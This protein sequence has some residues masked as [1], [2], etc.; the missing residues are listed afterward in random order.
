MFKASKFFSAIAES[1]NPPW[2]AVKRNFRHRPQH[3]REKGV[4][5]SPETGNFPEASAKQPTNRKT[6]CEGP[7]TVAIQGSHNTQSAEVEFDFDVLSLTERQ[8]GN[9]TSDGTLSVVSSSRSD[10]GSDQ[11][12]N[13]PGLHEADNLSGSDQAV[14]LSVSVTSLVKCD[15]GS[16]GVHLEEFNDDLVSEGAQKHTTD[17][18]EEIRPMLADLSSHTEPWSKEEAISKGDGV[19]NISEALAKKIPQAEIAVASD[20]KPS[21]N[22]KIN[23][24]LQADK[25]LTQNIQ[26]C[27]QALFTTLV[28][29]LRCCD[30]KHF[31]RL[32]LTGFVDSIGDASRPSFD[33]YL[34][35]GRDCARSYWVESKCTFVRLVV[36]ATV[37]AIL[38]SR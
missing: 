17:C 31:M 25:F 12:D 14:S 36:C 26:K 3:A 20:C 21:N 32:K 28:Q 27:L 13:C 8:V 23:S 38:R 7:E 16:T 1:L 15:I 2:A 37:Y 29:Q 33:L 9:E 4:V 34:S 18:A 24:E 5:I 19:L 11:A 30:E 6:Q 10:N 35:N 22:R